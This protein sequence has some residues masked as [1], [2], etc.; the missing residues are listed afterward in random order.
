MS[1][2]EE[3]KKALFRENVALLTQLVYD[4]GINGE[5]NS[6]SYITYSLNKMNALKICNAD[7]QTQG[8][9]THTRG[10]GFMSGKPGAILHNGTTWIIN[11][12]LYGSVGDRV[13]DFMFD[14]NGDKGPNQLGDDQMVFDVYL[15]RGAQGARLS[16]CDSNS[17]T[18][19]HT[20]MDAS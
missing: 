9:W 16:P 7:A 5:F 10:A 4:G 20:M 19:Y 2:E 6:S 14:W 18:L 12:D 1:T 15:D 3:K 13:T 17:L 11:T 8:C